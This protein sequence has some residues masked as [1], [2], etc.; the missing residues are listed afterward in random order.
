MSTTSDIKWNQEL[1]FIW[2][3]LSYADRKELKRQVDHFTNNEAEHRDEIVYGY[4]GEE[5]VRSVARAVSD[6]VL[7]LSKGEKLKVLDVGCGAG[8]F[9]VQIFV[10]LETSGSKIRFYGMDLTPAMLRVL[11]KKTKKIIPFV[12][13]ASDIG[14]AL[15]Y[16]RGHMVIPLKFNFVISV[17]TLHHIPRIGKVFKS[18]SEILEEDGTAIVVDMLEHPFTEWKEEM[19]DYHLGFKEKVIEDSASQYFKKV[20]IEKL[21]ADCQCSESGR[22]ASLF[23][24]TVSDRK[25]LTRR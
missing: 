19:G 2:N 3:S 16:A 21:P 5:G 22:S 7:S 24:A 23:M 20:N 25:N 6:R 15:S 17:L 12:G 18:I 11:S 9:S 4:F 10:D 13:N 1:E 14:G 8:T